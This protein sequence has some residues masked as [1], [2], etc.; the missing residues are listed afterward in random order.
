MSTVNTNAEIYT[1]WRDYYAL[2]KPRVVML[3]VFTA[4]VA[5]T[6]TG[7]Y[8][9]R[10]RYGTL[11]EVAACLRVAAGLYSSAT[12]QPRTLLQTDGPMTHAGDPRGAARAAAATR[13]VSSPSGRPTLI[14]TAR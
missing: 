10:W 1:D 2:T 7:L 13:S 8:V 5:G 4:V 9:H 14:L 6:A 11:D 12:P 3:I